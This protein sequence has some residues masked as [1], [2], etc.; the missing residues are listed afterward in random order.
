VV[1]LLQPLPKQAPPS[2]DKAGPAKDSATGSGS[3]GSVSDA[4]A[5]DAGSTAES[6]SPRD[7]L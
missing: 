7:E 5:S 6:S 2:A 1:L 3:E 4:S